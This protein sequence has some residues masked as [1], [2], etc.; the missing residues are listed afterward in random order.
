MNLTPNTMKNFKLLFLLVFSLISLGTHSQE[1]SP[2]KEKIKELKIAFLTEQLNL[3]IEEAEKFW[4]I[5]NKHDAILRKI[6]IDENSKIR[7]KIKDA[8]SL[9]NISDEDSEKLVKEKLEI[10]NRLL[11]E[12]KSFIK[13]LSTFLPFNKIL[14]FHIA[15][16]KFG[17]KLLAR[18]KRG[19]NN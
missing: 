16:R 12:N 10:D 18:Y 11:K 2:N 15:E 8:G 17:R 5:Y 13:E 14:K 9:D 3:T 1:K 6:R 4:P 7:R 19:R